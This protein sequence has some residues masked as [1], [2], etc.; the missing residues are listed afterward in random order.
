MLID[1]QGVRRE[2][3]ETEG[4]GSERITRGVNNERRFSWVVDTV[5]QK[6]G[7]KDITRIDQ[8]E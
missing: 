3:G 6:G 2:T 5:D 1:Q 7:G 8:G 4:R